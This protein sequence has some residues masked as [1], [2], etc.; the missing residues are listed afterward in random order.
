MDRWLTKFAASKGVPD[1]NLTGGANLRLPTGAFAYG[2]PRYSTTDGRVVDAWPITS[3]LVVLT[4]ELIT[5]IG[6]NRRKISNRVVN[7]KHDIIVSPFLPSKLEIIFL[8][9]T[10]FE[11]I[12]QRWIV[13]LA[14]LCGT[15]FMATLHAR[16]CS[17]GRHA[18][19]GNASSKGSISIKTDSTGSLG[20]SQQLCNQVVGIS[21]NWGL[22]N[23]LRRLL[24]QTL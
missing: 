12:W 7:W 17:N 4:G 10:D 2:I 16:I 9:S 15:G 24:V 18:S 11:C 14:V 13:L 1:T 6:T 23:S 3:P 20:H 8:R 22:Y 5:G 19:L 21:L